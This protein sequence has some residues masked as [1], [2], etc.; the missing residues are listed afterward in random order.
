MRMTRREMMK[1]SLASLCA[2]QFGGQSG[3]LFAGETK[4]VYQVGA[5]LG[6]L[7]AFDQAKEVG[8]D[9][10]QISFPL[11][12]TNDDGDF[13][14]PEVCK[15]F[16][17]KS[18]ETGVKISSLAMGE[19]N[20]KPFWQIDDAVERVF[21][22]ID[23]MVRL[24]VKSV[25]ISYF[26]AGELTTDDRFEETIKRYKELAPKAEDAGVVLAVES[27]LD[28][29]GHLRIINEVDSPSVAV[30]YDP[31]NMIHRFP[32]TDAVCDDIMK[33][34]GHI[35][36]VHIKDSTIIGKGRID[37]AKI[38]D[39]YRAVGFFGPQII[40]GSIDSDLG[41]EE[42]IRQNIAFIKSH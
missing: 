23:A 14:N 35:D 4:N 33:L 8:L 27:T 41:W 37:Y 12:P 6:G 16:L 22:C 36:A 9:V 31:G 18:A 5:W 7:N 17:D 21:E 10:L 1:L 15:K 24:D 32:D 25:L 40:E 13:R 26:G 2:A 29:A 3:G 38:L 34:K 28:A 30:F 42:S 19:F 20:G 11:R 39:A